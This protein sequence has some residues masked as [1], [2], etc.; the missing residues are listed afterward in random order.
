M[1]VPHSRSTVSQTKSLLLSPGTDIVEVHTVP[2]ATGPPP[3]KRKTINLKYVNADDLT[4]LRK[5]DPFMY[6]SIPKATRA[7]ICLR[8]VD[9]SRLGAVHHESSQ[10]VEEQG[11]KKNMAQ[12]DLVTRRSRISLE[13]SLDLILGECLE[14]GNPQSGQYDGY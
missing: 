13:C 10:E 2:T 4:S 12:S 8:D 5:Q 9:N 11:N 1:K 14:Q 6:Y 7:K 3:K